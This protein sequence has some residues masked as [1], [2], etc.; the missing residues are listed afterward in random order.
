MYVSKYIRVGDIK[1]NLRFGDINICMVVGY[2][3][4]YLRFG[5]IKNIF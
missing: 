2:K 4:I 5:G 3:Y 1:R